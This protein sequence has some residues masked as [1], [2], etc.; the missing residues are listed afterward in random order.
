MRFLAI[1]GSGRTGK[2]VINELLERGHQVTALIRNPASLE[3]RSGLNIVQGT[4]LI[5]STRF[6]RLN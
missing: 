3:E 2:L 1:G 4:R 6:D 5:I